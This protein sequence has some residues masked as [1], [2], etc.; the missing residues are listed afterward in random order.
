MRRR[1]SMESHS[2]WFEFEGDK[3]MREVQ[4]SDIWFREVHPY[5][6]EWQ[7]WIYNSSYEASHAVGIWSTF[8]RASAA[9]DEILEMITTGGRWVDD[10]GDIYEMTM[11]VMVTHIEVTHVERV[12]RLG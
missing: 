7:V 11:C 4:V 12:R 3:T 1:S 8:D 6:G 5:W 9:G 2:G 10:L